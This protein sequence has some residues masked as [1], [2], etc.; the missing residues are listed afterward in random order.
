M[1]VPDTIADPAWTVV[2]FEG[3]STERRIYMCSKKK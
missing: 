2:S 1:D 3:P